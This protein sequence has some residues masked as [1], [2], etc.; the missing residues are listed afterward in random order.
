MKMQTAE[1][2]SGNE[3]ADNVI[4]HR[5]MIAY[6]EAAARI[7]GDVLE[8]GSGE[9][10]GISMLAPRAKSYTG[11]DKHATPKPAGLTNVTLIQSMVP[12]LNDFKNYIFDFV[13][14]FQVVEHIRNDRFFLSEIHRVLK[15]GGTLILTTP[16]IRMSL[17][18]NPWHV[19]E[20]TL[21]GMENAIASSFKK[22]EIKGVFGN[23]KV[24][25][26]Y[27]ENKK[28]VR[29][30]TRYDILN[31]QYILPRAILKIPYDIANRLNR[32]RL[33][34]KNEGMVKDVSTDDYF[35]DAATD[36]CLDFFCLAV[37]APD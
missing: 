1:R 19:R 2:N 23:N 10:Y 37:K 13:V 14:S 28:S 30:F 3:A 15:P 33:M 8:I 32:N 11:I 25:G 22:F 17:T 31:L 9:G 12:P 27:E 18:R 5:H 16:N 4:H 34:K 24:M 29:K 21:S 20:Y 26:Y 6:R 7:S 35:I 36:R